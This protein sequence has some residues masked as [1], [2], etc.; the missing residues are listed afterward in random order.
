MRY[1]PLCLLT[2]CGLFFLAGCAALGPELDPP[3]VNLES[4]RAL[5]SSGGAPSF[6]MKLRVLNPNKQT[7]NIAGI[8]YTVE[9]LD[10]ELIAG[11]ANEI[12]P[13]ALNAI[14]FWVAAAVIGL[15]IWATSGLQ[16]SAE[17]RRGCRKRRRCDVYDRK[18]GT[19]ER[20]L[21]VEAPQ[22][23]WIPGASCEL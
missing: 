2:L 15:W 18:P 1:M 3:K 13:I 19:M 23:R 14:R 12:A 16:R 7:L 10:R 22:A 4:L 5:P 20:I 8:S 21:F 6:Q 17:S 11:V 9:L